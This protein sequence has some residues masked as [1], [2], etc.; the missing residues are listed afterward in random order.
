MGVP[1]SAIG[2]CGPD[3]VAAA[4]VARL[5]IVCSWCERVL[6]E[7]EPGA[8]TSHGICVECRKDVKGGVARLARL[9]AS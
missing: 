5:R 9:K 1:K 8:P 4:K 2:V 7:G 3:V 6:H